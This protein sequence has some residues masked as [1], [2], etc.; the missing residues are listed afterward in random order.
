[1]CVYVCATLIL[2]PVKRVPLFLGLVALPNT[3]KTNR[4]TTRVSFIQTITALYWKPLTYREIT[5]ANTNRRLSFCVDN[6]TAGFMITTMRSSLN[7][8]PDPMSAGRHESCRRPGKVLLC[9][10]A[11]VCPQACPQKASTR[12]YSCR[13]W[14]AIQTGPCLCAGSSI[15]S[16]CPASRAF[17]PARC[18]HGALK[19]WAQLHI[20][21]SLWLVF[22][23]CLT[24]SNLT[25]VCRRSS[26]L[27]RI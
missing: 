2:S 5:S 7:V 12:H 27:S 11:R 1:M 19:K 15:V 9:H 26:G 20:Y 17:T 3:G 14:A 6:F 16:C 4:E 21:S 10:H 23:I 8:G 24:A 25:C 22:P 13:L 18:P